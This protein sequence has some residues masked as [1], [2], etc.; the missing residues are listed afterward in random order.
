MLCRDG[1]VRVVAFI[2][3][4]VIPPARRG[5]VFSGLSHSSDWYAAEPLPVW[6]TKHITEELVV[7]RYATLIEGVAGGKIPAH[8]GPMPPDSINIWSAVISGNSLSPRTE[9][10][11]QVKNE[12][13]NEKTVA[14]QVGDLKFIKVEF[15]GSV[16]DDRVLSWPQPGNGVVPYGQTGG[17]TEP[18]LAA[19]RVG[20][21]KTKGGQNSKCTGDG[22]LFNVTQ[23]QAE[24]IDLL[25]PERV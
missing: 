14:L 7:G 3:G 18:A 11:H 13:F 24:E 8:T 20:A 5:A 17:Q 21:T 16:G 10:I 9:V 2:S 1:G 15:G 6:S 23:D 22:C 4:G 12:Y 25:A 19:C